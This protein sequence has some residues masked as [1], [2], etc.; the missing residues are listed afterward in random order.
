MGKTPRHLSSR[1]LLDDD[2]TCILESLPEFHRVVVTPTLAHVS[3]FSERFL[4]P[5]VLLRCSALCDSA[6]ESASHT[7]SKLGAQP[8]RI[9]CR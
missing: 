4:I 9:N 7:E 2:G 1:R 3:E 8:G 5:A 6:R